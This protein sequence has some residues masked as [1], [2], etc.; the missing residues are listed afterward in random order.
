MGCSADKQAGAGGDLN[1]RFI[2]SGLRQ[3]DSG[4]YEND[5]EKK[6]FF[7]IN[8]FR[9]EPKSFVPAVKRAYKENVLLKQESKEVQAELI[10]AIQSAEAMPPVSFEG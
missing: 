10:K 3:P 8:L 6:I 7:A 5:F 2:A 4:D 1:E 9:Y